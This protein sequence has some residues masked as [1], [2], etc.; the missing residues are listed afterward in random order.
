M[1]AVHKK[2]APPDAAIGGKGSALQGVS[3]SDPMAAARA[4]FEAVGPVR[5]AAATLVAQAIGGLSGQDA[6]PEASL[7]QAETRVLS[8]LACLGDVSNGLK[9]D[10]DTVTAVILADDV[11]DLRLQAQDHIRRFDAIRRAD[12]LDL[13]QIRVAWH[14]LERSV[15]TYLALTQARF[16]EAA[17]STDLARE[18]AIGE[19]TAQ[20]DTASRSMNM[21]SINASIEAAR[22]GSDGAGFMV[23]AQEMRRLSQRNERL[24]RDFDAARRLL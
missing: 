7:A 9:T 5:I 22:M 21:L 19:I 11:T 8:A 3:V 18:K 2:P 12:R 14:D 13:P 20:I 15:N 16:V 17:K 24:V 1:N 4:I 23:L 10:N 6:V